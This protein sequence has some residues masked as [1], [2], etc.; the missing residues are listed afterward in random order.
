[1]VRAFAEIEVS[2]LTCVFAVQDTD[3]GPVVGCGGYEGG[4]APYR[5]ALGGEAAG[6]YV[7]AQ[8]VPA[9]DFAEDALRGRLADPAELEV[10]A[11]THHAVVTAVAACGPVVPLPFATLFTDPDRAAASLEVRA[12]QFRALLDRLRD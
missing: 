4:S 9:A 8:D 10:L 7:V 6:L 12:G 3:G 2:T 1:M 5:L 11:R